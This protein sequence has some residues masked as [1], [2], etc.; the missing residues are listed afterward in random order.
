MSEDPLEAVEL[1]RFV[2]ARDLN[3]AIHRQRF[4]REI[5]CGGRQLADVESGAPCRGDSFAHALSERGA[6]RP[7]VAPNGDPRRFAAAE[8]LPGER[9]VRL[10]YGACG[11]GRE[12]FVYEAADVVLAEN[13]GG[14]DDRVFPP[15]W[16]LSPPNG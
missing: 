3:A 1:G 7:V 5:E 14:E 13:C 4:G 2:R 16:S 10:S 9:G 8:P 11:G 12:L 6:R 15:L